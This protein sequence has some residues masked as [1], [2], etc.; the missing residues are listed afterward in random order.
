MIGQFSTPEEV[1]LQDLAQHSP[2]R[3]FQT[4]TFYV[5]VF[6]MYVI[7]IVLIPLIRTRSPRNHCAYVVLNMVFFWLFESLPP[8][9]VSWIPLFLLPCFVRID[10]AQLLEYYIS[11]TTL[12]YIGYAMVMNEVEN[13]HLHKRLILTLLLMLGAKTGF[14]IGGFVMTAVIVS[15]WTSAVRTAAVL[16]PIAMEAIQHVQDNRLCHILELRTMDI[17]KRRPS[18]APPRIG[19]PIMEARFLID[20][21]IVIPDVIHILHEFFSVRKKLLIGI[22]FSAVLGSMGSVFGCGASIFVKALLAEIYNYHNLTLYNWFVCH[23]PLT[24]LCALLLWIIL[25]TCYLTESMVNDHITRRAFQ[26]VIYRRL[27]EL[28]PIKRPELLVLAVIIVFALYTT[29][30]HINNSLENE[31]PSAVATSESMAVLIAFLAVYTI[32]V[33]FDD[34]EWSDMEENNWD[35]RLRNSV[36]HL[37]WAL[38]ITIGAGICVMKLILVFDLLEY[39]EGMLPRR[40]VQSPFGLQL[41]VVLTALVMAEI[42]DSLNNIVVFTP[43][44]CCAS[45][46]AKIHPDYLLTPFVYCS[47]FGFLLPTATPISEFVADFADLQDDDFLL[48]GLALKLGCTSL[49][50][51]AYNTWCWDYLHLSHS[52]L[53]LWQTNDTLVA[54]AARPQN[55]WLD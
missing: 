30:R 43:L 41:V 26:D 2:Q 15:M 20:S 4:A 33:C 46:L 21:D 39:I 52:N 9:I 5:R 19:T 27:E 28:G 44:L 1:S 34:A 55:S 8:A 36:K 51:L 7:P 13:T 50:L 14:V 6:S 17:R 18:A 40:L 53:T 35:L 3:R 32:T 49:V 29:V 12:M 10:I 38:V 45:R 23:M 25:T 11:E 42:N 31:A 24:V 37:S 22:S 54:A 48:P 16:L 47:N